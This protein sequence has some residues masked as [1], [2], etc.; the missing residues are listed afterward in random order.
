[1]CDCFFLPNRHGA[2][3]P[4]KG[5][6]HRPVRRCKTQ[7]KQT[8]ESKP[9][10]SNRQ[11]A[12]LTQSQS[13][14]RHTANPLPL[15]ARQFVDI[16]LCKLNQP[17]RVKAY[18]FRFTTGRTVGL[19]STKVLPCRIPQIRGNRSHSPNYIGGRLRHVKTDRSRCIWLRDFST[20]ASGA[21]DSE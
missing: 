17:D 18:L 16:C 1:M 12:T 2:W 21:V 15:Y 10:K 3:T 20:V 6:C 8:R 19:I 9:N 14:W 11:Y 5:V 13:K 7:G 4:P